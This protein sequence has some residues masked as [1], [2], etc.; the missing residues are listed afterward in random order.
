[1]GKRAHPQRHKPDYTFPAKPCPDKP[2]PIAYLGPL[3]AG[4]ITGSYLGEGMSRINL[5]RLRLRLMANDR[6]AY[7]ITA[8][9][10]RFVIIDDLKAF[11]SKTAAA[12]S[13]RSPC[14]ER[15]GSGY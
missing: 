2:R 15:G 14:A 4:E 3:G 5:G 11:A 8:L 9:C 6:S 13:R 1:M 7:R 12:A 10:F